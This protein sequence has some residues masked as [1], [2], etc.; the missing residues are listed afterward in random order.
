MCVAVTTRG[1]RPLFGFTYL[2]IELLVSQASLVFELTG[3]DLTLPFSK[4]GSR[5]SSRLIV[6]GLESEV[7]GA[8]SSTSEGSG[9]LSGERTGRDGG[10]RAAVWG[11][12]PDGDRSS[13]E[14]SLEPRVKLRFWFKPKLPLLGVEHVKLLRES[15]CWDGAERTSWHLSWMWFEPSVGTTGGKREQTSWERK[16]LC[17]N[18]SGWICHKPYLLVILSCERVSLGHTQY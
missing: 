6:S 18:E 14:P 4:S 1:H 13:P 10:R 15:T 7:T 9:L 17:K 3:S 11:R 5:H 12:W 16:D 2:I 8:S